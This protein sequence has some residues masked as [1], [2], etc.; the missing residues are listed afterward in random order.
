MKILGTG[1]CLPKKVVTNDMLSEFLE[2]NDEWISTRTG[3]RERRVITDERLEDIAIAAAKNAL[4]NAG[5]SA[6]DLD[7]IICGNMVNEYTTPG[8]SC[9]IQGGI[10]ATCPCLDIN[11]ACAGF[12]YA[13]EVAEALYIAKKVK[14]VLIVCAEE[15]SRMI[16]W[17][18]RNTCVLFGDGAGATVL[19]EG[20]NIIGTKMTADCN[21]DKLFHYHLLE[22]SPFVTKE[23]VNLPMQ[24]KGREIFKFAVRIASA[25]ILTLL[26]ENGMTCD[27]VDYFIL[28]QANLRINTAIQEALQ[29]PAEKF[30]TNIEKTGNI[31][32]AS[33]PVLLDECNRKGMFKKGDKIIF[34]GFGAG[35]VSGVA[36]V[37]WE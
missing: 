28:H 17:T 23:E 32:S 27:D 19:G 5:V 6:A 30:P 10:G 13:I 8:L 18:D 24:M 3:I 21:I 25:D 31:T 36:L 4:E 22:P 1:A 29:Q 37:E 11:C 35:F 9:I 34:S 7:Y 33:C 26:E 14:N 16:D 20:S 15:P 12:V 2:T